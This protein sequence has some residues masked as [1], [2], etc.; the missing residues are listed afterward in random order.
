MSN[1]KLI[2][3]SFTSGFVLMATEILASRLVA[4][5]LGMSTPVWAAII[6][7]VLGGTA[8]GQWI[9]GLRLKQHKWHPSLRSLLMTAGF[10]VLALPLF[11]RWFM[12]ASLLRFQSGQFF[13][14]FG[15]ALTVTVIIA[16]PALL[17]GMTGPLLFHMARPNP[18]RL[19]VLASRIYGANTIG[20]LLGTYVAAFAMV[21][22]IGTRSALLTCGGILILLGSMSLSEHRAK[23]GAIAVSIALV[24]IFIFPPPQKMGTRIVDERE[25]RYN[26]I[27]VVDVGAKRQ[28]LLNDGYAIQSAAWKSGRPYL[29]SVWGYYALAP[30]YG[31]LPNGPK[32]LLLLGFGAGSVAHAYDA[33]YP[34]IAITGVE[35]DSTVISMAKRWFSVPEKTNIEVGDARSFVNNIGERF[36]VIILDAF[37]FP[38]IPF[39]LTTREFY[40]KLAE[41]LNEGGVLI[42]NVGRD[43]DARG[44]V[45]AVAKTLGT[46]FRHV[47]GVDVDRHNTVLLAKQHSDSNGVGLKALKIETKHFETLNRLKKFRPWPTKRDDQILTDNF[48][49]IAWMTDQIIWRHVWRQIF[50]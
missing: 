43:K 5:F 47:I 14:L 22:Y 37:R 8:L 44:V 6:G 19:G 26:A 1:A 32:R 46:A 18:S 25:S 24:A 17:L 4:P 31:A 48:A 23:A 16:S 35:L 29:E 27:R 21:P 3:I 40:K 42:V 36:D 28:L 2:I 39:Y 11:G 9:I 7:A 20:S 13:S 15:S 38:Y 49:P 10:F 30:A 33:L 34:G 45:N 41:L 50:G 12:G